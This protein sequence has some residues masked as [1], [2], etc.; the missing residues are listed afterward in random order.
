MGTCTSYDGDI[1]QAIGIFMNMSRGVLFF[2]VELR[3]I[4][5]QRKSNLEPE[6]EANLKHRKKYR[7]SL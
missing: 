6:L 5:P 2:S 4:L 3:A 1:D 7:T